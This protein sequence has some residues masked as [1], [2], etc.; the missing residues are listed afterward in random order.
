VSLE[1]E[2]NQV[3]RFGGDELT[4]ALPAMHPGDTWEVADHTHF[5]LQVVT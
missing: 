2:G 3:A 1:T 5:Q 4:P